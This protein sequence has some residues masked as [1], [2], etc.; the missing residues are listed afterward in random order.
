MKPAIYNIGEH[1][2]GF[3]IESIRRNYSAKDDFVRDITGANLKAD[4]VKLKKVL[5]I[6]WNEAFPQKETKK[7]G[8]E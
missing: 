6:V 8:A 4:K 1:S 3:S 7:E 2:F 5:D